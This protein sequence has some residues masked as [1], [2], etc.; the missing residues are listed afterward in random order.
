MSNLPPIITNPISDLTVV[1]NAANTNLDLLTNFDD[2]LT[3]GKIATFELYN[4]DLAGGIINVLLFD[5]AEAGAPLTVE[6][7]INYVEDDDYE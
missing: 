5:Q 7:F 2:T 1:E 6:N 4:T 3:T